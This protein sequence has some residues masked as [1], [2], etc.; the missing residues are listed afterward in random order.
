MPIADQLR[1]TLREALA[2]FPHVRLGVLFGSQARGT[3]HAESDVDVDVQAPALEGPAIAAA[4]SAACGR[5]VDVVTL[6]DP[7]IPLLEAL[8][9]DGIVIFEAV[10]G[11]G[12]SWR[13]ATLS[14]LELD[15][16]WYERMSKAWL[17]QVAREG[18]P[19]STAR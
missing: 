7:P 4:L 3:A 19:G 5:E 15:R 9:H 14:M 16:P 13:A 11:T 1:D 10:P 17:A 12:A 2:S 8:I 18:L 6:D